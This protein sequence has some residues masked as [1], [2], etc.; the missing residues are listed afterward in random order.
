MTRNQKE[1]LIFLHIPKT[2]GSTINEVL[3]WKYK[4]SETFYMNGWEMKKSILKFK[5]L[6]HQKRDKIK[7]IVGHIPFGVHQALSNPSAYITMLRQPVDRVV[8]LYYYILR[9]PNHYLHEQIISSQIS[10]EDFVISRMTPEL[11]NGQTRLLSG[12][13]YDI[14]F[15]R[16]TEELRE[17]T[18]TN[19]Q[20]NFVFI[21]IQEKFNESILLLQKKVGIK[22][23]PFYLSQNVSKSRLP[24]TALADKV[25]EKVNKNNHLDQEIYE[26]A[27]K[28]FD[29][30]L[31]RM[32]ITPEKVRMF[33]RINNIYYFYK[34]S[35]QSTVRFGKKTIK[36]ILGLNR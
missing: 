32:S 7:L 12:V 33:T 16:C 28:S 24:T 27:R 6:P 26:Y 15:G 2:A 22:V 9:D 18:I 10:L 35:Q 14:P 20:N 1:I 29:E 19:L 31:I 25:I 17:S 23:W 11:D 5:N 13:G 4:S 34:V 3:K 8:S 30:E 36:K 21:G